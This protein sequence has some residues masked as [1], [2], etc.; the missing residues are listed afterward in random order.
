MV[1]LLEELIKILYENELDYV[2]L[3][4]SVLGAVRHKGIIPWDDDIDIGLIREDFE[5]LEEYLSNSELK[6]YIFEKSDNH[7]IPDAPI[8]KFRKIVPNEELE[9]YPTIDIFSLDSA[10][11]SKLAQS[12]QIG[13]GNIYNLINYGELPQNR[14]KLVKII[15]SI[16]LFMVQG[17]TKNKL[18]SF[19]YS[20][21]TKWNNK[22]TSFITNLYGYPKKKEL[23]HKEILEKKIIVEFNGLKCPIPKEFDFYLT[24]LYGD[25]NKLPSKEERI[26][27]HV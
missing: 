5:K 4:G 8:A 17:K 13:Y 16:F 15:S 9:K 24:Q 3:G 25:Y 23:F 26:P 20:R 1:E 21:L 2:L 11:N 10:P 14:G 6:K 22:N 19:F 12:I 27:K 18:S 7:I